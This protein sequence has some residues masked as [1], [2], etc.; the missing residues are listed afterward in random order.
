ME[1][2]HVM[3]DIETLGQKNR[4]VIFAI[5]AVHFDPNNYGEIKKEFLQWIDLDSCLKLGYNIEADTL[6]WWLGQDNNLLKRQLFDAEP[7][8]DFIQALKN[9]R[10][11]F[12]S[13]GP[14]DYKEKKVFVWG[15]S[16]FDQSQI[17]TA[18]VQNGMKSPIY[19]RNYIDMRTMRIFN[20]YFNTAGTIA[21]SGGISTRRTM[22]ERNEHSLKH[23][24]Y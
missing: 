2:H 15:D 16:A 12:W 19:F 13:I 24:P 14:S 4:P 23:R 1:F 3:L 21:E 17:E 6:K 10:S 20:Y 9:F 8:V 18:Y 11:W 5:A 7:R 22:E